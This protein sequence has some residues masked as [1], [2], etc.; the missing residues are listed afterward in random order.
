MTNYTAIE[1]AFFSAEDF[2]LSDADQQWFADFS[3]AEEAHL[4]ALAAQAEE[5]ATA[6]DWQRFADFC[7]YRAEIKDAAEDTPPHW[8]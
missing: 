4:W 6:A 1:S 7:E 2:Q 3:D 5:D 8:D